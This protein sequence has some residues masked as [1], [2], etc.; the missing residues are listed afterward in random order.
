[1][2]ARFEKDHFPAAPF[3]IAEKLWRNKMSATFDDF[4]KRVEAV[5]NIP[6]VRGEKALENVEMLYRYLM[7]ILKKSG[8]L[9]Q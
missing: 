4:V 9:M 5:R 6:L 3:F 1:M 7:L 8:W 2:A